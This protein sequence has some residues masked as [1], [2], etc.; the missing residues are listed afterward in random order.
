MLILYIV[1]RT[2]KQP[3]VRQ[4]IKEGILGVPVGALYESD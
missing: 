2:I 1:K 4:H 3:L